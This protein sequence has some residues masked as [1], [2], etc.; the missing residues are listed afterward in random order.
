MTLMDGNPSA[1][2]IAILGSLFRLTNSKLDLR[3]FVNDANILN[4][5]D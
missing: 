5:I 4:F 1:I 2:T 3:L